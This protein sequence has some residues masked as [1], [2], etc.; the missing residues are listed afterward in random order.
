MPSSSVRT[1]LLLFP[2]V[3]ELPWFSESG[4]HASVWSRLLDQVVLL[5]FNDLRSDLNT[6]E[7]NSEK[8]EE[9]I[10]GP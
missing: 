3:A 2:T 9:R 7:T 8:D 5:R 4:Y 10:R 6:L 1:T